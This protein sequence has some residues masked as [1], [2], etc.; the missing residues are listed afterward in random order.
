MQLFF[1]WLQLSFSRNS[2]MLDFVEET[3]LS[4]SGHATF[5]FFFLDSIVEILLRGHRKNIRGKWIYGY[6]SEMYEEMRMAVDNFIASHK[7]CLR[8]KNGESQKERERERDWEWR[9]VSWLPLGPWARGNMA[10]AVY[11]RTMMLLHCFYI[12]R[13]FSVREIIYLSL[14]LSLALSIFY[15]ASFILA[16]CILL[17]IWVEER[18]GS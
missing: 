17:W 5:F 6:T 16:V 7:V 4:F 12:G 2:G 3:K 8:V 11:T 14:S 9:A 10:F 15:A 13:R 18:I 1:S